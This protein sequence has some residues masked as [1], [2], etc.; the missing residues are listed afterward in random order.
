MASAACTQEVADKTQAAVSKVI[1]GPPTVSKVEI[2]AG[3]L[4]ATVFTTLPAAGG[5]AAIKLCNKVATLVY[6]VG[7][8]GVSVHSAEDKLLATG[9][10]GD[11][12]CKQE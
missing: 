6:P 5:A 11:E 1:G 9:L 7:V 2:S 4:E 12:G 3:C 8:L 10:R